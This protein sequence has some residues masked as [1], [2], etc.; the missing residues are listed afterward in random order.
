MS[1]KEFF[2]DRYKQLGWNFKD[3][4]PTQAI[5]INVTNTKGKNI[6]ERLQNTG[7]Q[8]EKVPFLKTGY[9]IQRSKIS[10]GAT[11]EYLL[12]LYSI[13]EAAAQIPATLFTNL[14]DKL[15]RDA[16]AAP[17]GKTV[18]LADLMANTG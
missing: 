5:W 15:V 4:Q 1:G 13:Q 3:V 7:V 14:K 18:Q 2:V 11:A 9:W 17:G 6:E 10:V 8:L 12:G 16:G